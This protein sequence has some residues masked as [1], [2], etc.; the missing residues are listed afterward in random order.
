[1]QKLI[2]DQRMIYKCCSLYYEDNIGQAEIAAYLGISKSSVSRMLRLGRETGIVEIR[3]HHVARYMYAELEDQVREKYRLRDVV[4]AESSP[5]DSMEGKRMKLNERAADYFHRLF[6]DGD[7]IGVS[8]GSTLHNIATTLQEFPEKKCTFV[9]VVGGMRSEDVQANK[10]AEAFAQKFGGRFV[11]FFSPAVFSSERL[12]R[13]FLQ[14]E[15]VRFIFDY[16]EKLDTIIAGMGSRSFNYPTLRK[17]DFVT[18]EQIDDFLEKGAVGILCHRFLDRNGNTDPFGEF[19][20]RTAAISSEC[21]RRVK[22]KILVTG[23]DGK[24]EVLEGCINGGFVN[25]L[26]TDIDCARELLS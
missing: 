4:I 26:I 24:K 2:N 12:M 10:V 14:E 20:R 7:Y 16:F 25:I 22:N 9:P 19:N 18:K 15:S 5:L 21:Y 13:E 11:S 3:V 6:K 23:G 8:V 17:L 1:M